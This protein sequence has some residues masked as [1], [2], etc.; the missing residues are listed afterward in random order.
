MMKK[1]YQNNS[2]KLVQNNP[3]LQNKDKDRGR[4]KE[5]AKS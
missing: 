5:E 3:S 4:R 1:I 2:W